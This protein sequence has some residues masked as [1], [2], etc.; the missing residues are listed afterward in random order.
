MAKEGAIVAVAARNADEIADVAARCGGGAIAVQ[1][2]VRDE[3]ACAHA[4]ERCKAELGA[5]HVLVNG[6]GIA[7]SHKF[8][9]LPTNSWREIMATDLDGPFFMTKAAIRPMLAAGWG[10]VIS[11]GSIASRS[12]APYVA[13]YTAA[14]HGLL[15][16]MRS[17]AAEYAETSITFNCV[18]PAFSDTSMTDQTVRNIAT[19]TGRTPEEARLALMTPQ[20]R[21]ISPGEV[22]AASVFLASE[23]GRSINGQAIV[24][25]GGGLLA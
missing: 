1:L 25:D 13:A 5:L 23:A 12:G 20:G 16:L 19:R 2:D 6:A 14:K 17:L 15:G 4:V 7:A 11:I 18:C 8:T 10:R 24:V 9:E 3:S 21:L 22:A